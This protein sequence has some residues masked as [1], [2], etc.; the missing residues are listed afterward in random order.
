MRV[1]PAHRTPAVAE[2]DAD[3]EAFGEAELLRV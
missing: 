2:A 1:K 3:G